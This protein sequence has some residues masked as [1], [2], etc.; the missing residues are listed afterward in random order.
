MKITYK[1]VLD[2]LFVIIVWIY[3]L[4]G[5]ISMMYFWWQY[6][7]KDPAVIAICIDPFLAFLKGLVWPFFI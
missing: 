7:Q 5:G 6:C 4:I 1:N 2:I 3:C